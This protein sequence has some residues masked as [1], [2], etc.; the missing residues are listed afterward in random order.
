MSEHEHNKV[1]CSECWEQA[2]GRW[3]KQ[4]RELRARLALAEKVDLP[5][6]Q[7]L[8]REVLR[9]RDSDL[10]DGFPH[11]TRLSIIEWLEKYAALLSAGKVGEPYDG[12]FNQM[13]GNGRPL[14]P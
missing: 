9:W 14:I 10:N 1:A 8:F 12:P 3:V 11:D 4:I 13:D 5:L 2:D 6:V 7:R